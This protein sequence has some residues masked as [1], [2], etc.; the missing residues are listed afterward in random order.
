MFI[1]LRSVRLLK[2]PLKSKSIGGK[3]LAG[4]KAKAIGAKLKPLPLAAFILSKLEISK[5]I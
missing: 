3:L 1:M 5:C 4:G 2:G